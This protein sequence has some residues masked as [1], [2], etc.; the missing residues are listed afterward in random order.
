VAPGVTRELT[1]F[2]WAIRLCGQTQGAGTRAENDSH[3]GL[4]LLSIQDISWNLFQSRS[5]PLIQY[6][7]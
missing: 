1:E 7:E 2:F 6:I 5:R 4:V 3:R